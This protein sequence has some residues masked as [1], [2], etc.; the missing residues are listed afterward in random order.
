MRVAARRAMVTVDDSDK[1]KRALGRT[2]IFRKKQYVYYG[3]VS[4]ESETYGIW[5]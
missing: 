5:K 2:N 3:R 4:K 1:L